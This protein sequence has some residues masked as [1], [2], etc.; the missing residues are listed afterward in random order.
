MAK[1]KQ[2]EDAI[3]IVAP[4]RDTST[5]PTPI[6]LA[7]AAILAVFFGGIALWG[8][9]VPLNAAVN[10][11]GEVVF[12]NKRQ[13]V[14]HQE[15]GI[16]KEI[17]VK[18]GSTVAAGQP[19][20]VLESD[21]IKPVVDM[22][23]SQAVAET[24]SIIR[25]QAERDD[26]PS[27]HFPSSIPDAVVL[28]ETKLFNA[29]L[30]AYKKQIDVLKSQINQSKELIK[31]AE[32]QLASKQKEIASIKEQLEANQKLRK[33]RYVTKTVVLDLE[34]ILAE[35]NGERE[36]IAGNIATNIQRQEELEQRILALRADRI[37]QAAN[38]IKQSNMRR[39]E[40]EERVRPSIATMAHQIIRAPVAGKVVGLKI[41]T[42][43]GVVVPREPLMDIAPQTDHLIIDGKVGV[44]DISDVKLGQKAQV[45]FT[46]FKSSEVPSV[47]AHV[48][49][50]SDDR[51]T[52]R[53]AQGDSPYY[54]ASLELDPESLKTLS[55]L[56]LVP[57][58]Q[59]QV[60]ISTKPRTALDY[61]LGPLRDR[62]GRAFHAK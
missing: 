18:D 52:I 27:V 61:F 14:Q 2:N 42:V 10:A 60:S 44:N 11:Q 7:G 62:M 28:T 53:T 3:L 22:F 39:A 16:V 57:G 59:A 25:L 6:I 13:S 55:G 54:S 8:I 15:G 19:L 21:Q 30:Q 29:K 32:E 20:I 31:G 48:T 58:M 35:K 23:Q 5:S 38:E 49:Y 9:F 26:L 4:K 43:G 12:Q 47:S 41:S 1:L 56:Q 34:R 24:A 50:I 51:L 33:A 17:L 45:T 37:Q 46:A 40:L 36:Q